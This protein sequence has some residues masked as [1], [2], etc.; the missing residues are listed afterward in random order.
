M[1]GRVGAVFQVFDNTDREGPWRFTLAAGQ[2]HAAGHWNKAGHALGPY[3]LTV[4]G[5]NGFHRRFAGDTSRPQPVVTVAAD[6]RA[7]LVISLQGAGLATLRMAEDYPLAEG[8]ARQTVMLKPRGVVRSIWDLRGSDHWYDL[9]LTL[10]D[11]PSFT[12][13]PGRA[14]G[15]R[16]RQPHRSGHRP[17]APL[18]LQFTDIR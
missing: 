11:D 14:P 5:P 3:D 1:P 18:S 7:R 4:H 10:A 15:N 9:T 17:Y 12:P 6:A 16:P 2:K 8:E 13:A